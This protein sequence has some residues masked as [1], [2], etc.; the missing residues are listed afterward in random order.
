LSQVNVLQQL[1]HLRSYPVLRAR[2]EAGEVRLHAWW[3]DLAEAEV[4]RYEAQNLR[5]EVIG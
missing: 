4:L 2:E 3:F 5:F 1:E